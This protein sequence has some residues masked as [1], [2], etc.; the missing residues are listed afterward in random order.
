MARRVVGQSIPRVDAR[1][2]VT[3]SA[4]YAIDVSR[5]GMLYGIVVRS[6]RAHARIKVIHR[7]EAASA[8]GVIAVIT[9]EDLG[10]LDPYYGHIIRDHPVLAVDRV[11]FMGE[12]VA[13]VVGSS[14]RSAVAA[15]ELVVVDY[16]DLDPVIDL[17][18]AL[19]PDAPLVHDSRYRRGSGVSWETVP[20]DHLG[21]NVAHE[22]HLEWGDVDSAMEAAHLALTT[23]G[24]F[25]MLY[26]YAMEPYNALAEYQPGRLHVISST[27]HPFMV[28]AELARILQVPHTQVHVEAPYVGGGYGSKSWTK[29]E[30]LAAVG[31]FLTGRPVKVAL[32]VE[33]A[34]LTTRADSARVTVRTGFDTDGRILARELKIDFNT[35]AYA[36]SSPSILDKSVHRSFGPYQIPNLRID[37]RLVY[38]NTVPA[39]SYRG[40]GAP[41]GNL[42]AEYNMDH[43]ASLLGIDPREIRRRNLVHPGGQLLPG[44]RPLD[45][46][47]A[48]DLDMLVDALEAEPE[49]GN[50]SDDRLAAIGFGCSASDAGAFPAST[51]VVRIGP[52]GSVL[53]TT[54]A[55]EMGQGS[56]TV[57]SQIA[58]EELGLTME[59]VAFAQASTIVGPFERATNGSRTTTL[60]G[61]AV[62]RAAA[63][64]LGELRRMAADVWSVGPERIEVGDGEVRC[65]DRRATYGEVVTA[66]FGVDGGEAIGVGLVRREGS[67]APMPPFWEIGMAGVGVQIDRETGKVTLDRLATV[68]DVGCAIN[69]AAMEGQDLGAATQG[70][71]GALFEE[72]VYDGAQLTNPNLVDY[73]VPRS[74]DMARTIVTQLAERGDGVGPYGAK[75]GGEGSLNP[76]G[77]AVMSAI[78]RATGR[79]HS[80]VRLPMTPERVWRLMRSEDR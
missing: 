23:V 56:S 73:R 66:W 9:A 19:R 49:N 3:G 72:L 50:V 54:G 7:D 32:T 10:Q 36:D 60:V 62:Q 80:E 34:M 67:T 79:W 24:H 40:F 27:Q 1:A 43:A 44:K 20:D 55:V 13:L 28:R 33:E 78:A 68:G 14:R 52:E 45:A 38:T 58:A 47:L 35:G 6:D 65:D 41:Q 18:D 21:S 75:G 22:A 77:G 15:A 51:A 61:L 71:G 2:K 31:A 63:A 76:V 42:A 26:A 59:Q 69:P 11:R 25:P 30:P 4:V 37:A 64:A 12:P 48:S 57:L 5:P 46:D 29:V 39:S 53:V 16:E 74:T 70:L 17:D 8:P